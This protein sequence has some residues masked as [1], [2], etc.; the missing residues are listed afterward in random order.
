MF[1]E[2]DEATKIIKKINWPSKNPDATQRIKTNDD[3]GQGMK[4][5]CII[6]FLKSERRRWVASDM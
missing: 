5:G 3:L 6:K 4:E 2:P 1:L